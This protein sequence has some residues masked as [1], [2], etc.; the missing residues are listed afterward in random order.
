MKHVRVSWTALVLLIGCPTGLSAQS[1]AATPVGDPS[2]PAAGVQRAQ[3][4][5][6]ALP[7]ATLLTVAQAAQSAQQQPP[8]NYTKEQIEELKKQ[9]ERAKHQNELIKQASEAMTTKDWQAAVAP[10]QQLIADDPKNW[11]YHSVIG[12]VQYNLGAYDQAVKAYQQGIRLAE[13]GPDDSKNSDPA[14]KKAAIGKM[15]TQE[16]NAYLKL[17]KNKEAVAAF[18]KAASLDP[19]PATAYFNLCATQ[20]NIGNVEGA[21]DACGKAIAADP[22]KA[23][24]YF[25][26]GSLLVGESKTDSSGKVT[27]PP[28]AAEALKRYLELAPTG[29]HADDVK[30]LLSFIGSNVESTYKKGK[31][32]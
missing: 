14:K 32:K 26:K 8:P 6:A 29:A 21:L 17:R 27:A 23:D 18:T 20:Y 12:D 28:G 1:L 10:L 11:Q 2:L 19:N 13:S 9:N 16:G 5:A 24:A 25:I 30:Q 31:G 22:S 4:L 7:S 15:L 3:D